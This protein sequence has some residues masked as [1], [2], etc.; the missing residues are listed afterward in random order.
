MSLVKILSAA[1]EN[2]WHTKKPPYRHFNT[3]GK[4]GPVPNQN[5]A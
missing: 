2:F 5:C 4:P 1:L 3:F